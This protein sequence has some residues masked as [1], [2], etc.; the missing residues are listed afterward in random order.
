MAFSNTPGLLKPIP[1]QK[2][3]KSHTMHPYIISSG[4]CGLAISILSYSGSLKVCGQADE[5]I[6]KTPKPLI[7]KIE[8][9]L[10]LMI[11]QYKFSQEELENSTSVELSKN[12]KTK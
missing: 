7:D 5:A 3:K 10:D 9:K 1:F 2:G 4:K 11:N 8:K 12:K 6:M